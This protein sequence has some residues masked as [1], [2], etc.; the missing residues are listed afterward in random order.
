M[1]SEIVP[2]EDFEMRNP[3]LKSK[4]TKSFAQRS[5]KKKRNQLFFT[6]LFTFVCPF[7]TQFPGKFR[8]MVSK[9]HKADDTYKKPIKHIKCI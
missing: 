9:T 6:A 2:G 3:S 7:I 1:T 5:K 8:E 4:T